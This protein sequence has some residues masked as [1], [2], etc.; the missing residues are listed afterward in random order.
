MTGGVVV[1]GKFCFEEETN[2]T[3]HRTCV[4][5]GRWFNSSFMILTGKSSLDLILMALIPSL[6]MSL[7]S[8]TPLATASSPFIGRL[9][10]F[11]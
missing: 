8:W 10:P 9:A 5:P 1:G 6:R 4:L 3:A 11:F 7:F 2:L